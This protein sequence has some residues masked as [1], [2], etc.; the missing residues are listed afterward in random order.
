M[1]IS[2]ANGNTNDSKDMYLRGY[3]MVKM[4]RG[5]IITIS[6][7]IKDSSD[8]FNFQFISRTVLMKNYRKLIS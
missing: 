6:F 1:I 4:S 7:L 2:L 5:T 3:V 8:G